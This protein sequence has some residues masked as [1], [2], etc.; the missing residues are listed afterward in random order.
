MRWGLMAALLVGL[1]LV[2]TAQAVSCNE[3]PADW[4]EYTQ[5]VTMD[6]GTYYI[7]H[8]T[9]VAANDLVIDCNGAT[10]LGTQPALFAGIVV[11][12]HDNITIKNC[13]FISF[14]YAI[15]AEN[16]SWGLFTNNTLMESDMGI[17]VTHINGDPY[18]PYI[19]GTVVSNNTIVFSPSGVKGITIAHSKNAL[20][21]DNSITCNGITT[22]E[23]GIVV[24]YADMIY[25]VRDSIIEGNTITKCRGSA[26]R[27]EASASPDM[28]PIVN[29]TIRNNQVTF[30]GVGINFAA[31]VT[32]SLIEG[33]V[34]A[35]NLIG[36]QIAYSPNNT[37]SANNMTDNNQSIVIHDFQSFLKSGQPQPSRGMLFTDNIFLRNGPV[38]DE[39]D[40]YFNEGDM[41]NFYD[42]HA[43]VLEGCPDT[44]G[45]LR[46]DIEMVH[47]INSIDHS[48]LTP[49]LVFGLKPPQFDP[50]PQQITVNE[51]E[52]VDLDVNVVSE[53]GPLT[54]EIDDPNFVEVGPGSWKWYTD[55]TDTG[56]YY[57]TVTVR[58]SSFLELANQTVVPVVVLDADDTCTAQLPNG[59][60]VRGQLIADSQEFLR[61]S[62]IFFADGAVLDGQGTTLVGFQDGTGLDLS[63]TTGVTVKNIAVRN[64]KNGF[65]LSGA[66]DAQLLG[67]LITETGTSTNPSSPEAGILGDGGSN[68]T[69]DGNT[70]TDNIFKGIYLISVADANVLSNYLDRNGEDTGFNLDLESVTNSMISGNQIR[71]SQF[72]MR[73]IGGGSNTFTDNVGQF[74][75]GSSHDG[76]GIRLSSEANDLVY[77]NAFIENSKQGADSIQPTTNKFN[78]ST[79]GNFW[80]DH[81]CQNPVNNI[82]SNVYIILPGVPGGTNTDYLPLETPVVNAYPTI[83]STPTTTISN[84]EK[85][86]Y[87]VQTLDANDDPLTYTLLQGPPGMT[88]QQNGQVSWKP[89]ASGPGTYPVSVLVEDNHDGFDIQNF[90]LNIYCLFCHA[91]PIFK[92]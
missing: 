58:D 9:Y 16:S 63:G 89:F 40:N 11:K 22:A 1:L 69:I 66:T 39:Y 68:I 13:H 67:N 77:R 7:P 80:Y 29:H 72:C 31:G 3:T 30:S 36:I 76:F 52:I 50:V 44:N 20:V 78:S 38:F 88:I 71:R 49:E 4:C 35:N 48:P 23:D 61:P 56:T 47:D 70:I 79:E 33:N 53:N 27:L 82:C 51:G 55:F 75:Q 62:G 2:P 73:A 21:K 17:I 46:C 24:Q 37:V 87:K 34:I 54:Y 43:D 45:D 10:L 18:P 14:T 12:S 81:D 85:F 6:P 5:S 57:A 25:G 84:V 91:T 83:T 15:D 32:R 8:G 26:I 74:C 60:T 42:N 65:D 64:F 92:F 41:G 59:C 28:L 86:K 90:E 19:K